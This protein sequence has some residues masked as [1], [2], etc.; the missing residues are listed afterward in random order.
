MIIL[1]PSIEQIFS[2]KNVDQD[3][4]LI[5]E[6]MT[7][8]QNQIRSALSSGD[9][10][11]AIELF[12]QL[13]AS[14]AVHFVEDEHWCYFDDYY[15]PDYICMTVFDSFKEAINASKFLPEEVKMLRDGLLEIAS[16]EAVQDYGYPGVERWLK[17]D[18]FTFHEI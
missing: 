16:L 13:L 17:K 15:S 7:P 8:F 3:C 18:C 14:T 6:L 2:V 4:A 11:T 1:N 5:A 10:V 12:L 9:N